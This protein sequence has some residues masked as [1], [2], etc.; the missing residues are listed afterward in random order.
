MSCPQPKAPPSVEVLTLTV[1]PGGE[2]SS[3]EDLADKLHAEQCEH[4][5][6]RE[7]LAQAVRE[8]EALRAV[9]RAAQEVVALT[10]QCVST[11]EQEAEL[12]RRLAA[13]LLE[14]GLVLA[15][16]PEVYSEEV[17]HG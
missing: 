6:V 17:A 5:A 15:Q 9:R 10:T 7:R 13:G 1:H 16:V 14:L 3:C 12:Q 11:P 4:G 8:L 2:C